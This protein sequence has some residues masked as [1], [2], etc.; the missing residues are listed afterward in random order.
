MFDPVTIR[1]GLADLLASLTDDSPPRLR[2]DQRLREELGLDSVD[3][4]SFVMHVE[5]QYRISLTRLDLQ[6][7][8]TVGDLVRLIQCRVGRF[9]VP[10][11]A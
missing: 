9:R 7:T 10:L 11:A 4:V 3:I 8:R 5:A 1:Q 6:R 2:D